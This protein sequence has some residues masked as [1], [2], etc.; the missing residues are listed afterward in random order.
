MASLFEIVAR[1]R[2]IAE[3]RGVD[4]FTNPIIDAG[5]TAEALVPHAIRFILNRAMRGE[6]GSSLADFMEDHTIALAEGG[7]GILPA[8]V[9]KDHLDQSFLKGRP[10]SSYLPNFPDYERSRFNN[11]LCYYTNSGN[12]FR[13]S[14]Y[15]DLFPFGVW[16]F[17]S[18]P[19]EG[20]TIDINGVTHT[21]RLP[22]VVVAGAGDTFVNGEW[23]YRGYTDATY[24]RKLYNKVGQPTT[25]DAYPENYVIG[26]NGPVFGWSI[27]DGATN[28]QYQGAGSS[29]TPDLVP[30]W[31][32]T[33]GGLPAPTVTNRVNLSTEIEIGDSIAESVSNFVAALNASTNDDIEVATYAVAYAGTGRATAATGTYDTYGAE[34]ESFAMAASSAGSIAVSGA[35]FTGGRL[36]LSAPSS[37]EIPTDPD[38]D[39]GL[40][41]KVTDDVILTVAGALTGEIKIETL[42]G[43]KEASE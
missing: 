25:G 28:E 7:L 1:A 16:T 29:I 42:L 20:E 43:R 30:V 23:T 22:G 39:I 24:G 34:G 19:V 9:L 4:P 31:V 15:N 17:L 18:N 37:P 21:W 11:L 38:E 41:E 26:N 36:I 10:H 14:C 35:T 27:F 13:Y 32:D 33:G 12:D 5:M 8:R 3:G 2:Q 40:S 6:G